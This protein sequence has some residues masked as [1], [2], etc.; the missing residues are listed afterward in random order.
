MLLILEV[1]AGILLALG[2][3]KLPAIYRRRKLRKWF[4]SLP[5]SEVILQAKRND[6]YT[7][8][9][10]NL[11]IQLSLVQNQAERES[12]A[13]ELAHSFKA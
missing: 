5:S 8:D 12:L 3:W 7:S 13:S 2:I 6:L 11:I 9:Q 4:L 1:A 10:I